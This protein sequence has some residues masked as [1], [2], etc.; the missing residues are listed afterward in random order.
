MTVRTAPLGRVPLVDLTGWRGHLTA[1]AVV[2]FAILALFHADVWSMVSIWWNASTFGHCLFI[3]PLIAWLVQQRLSGLRQL[4]PVAWTP[5]LVWLALGAL[6]WLVGAAAG[7]AMVRHGALVVMLQGAT[8]ALLGPAVARAL[9]FPL[10][11]AFF[12]VPFGEEIVPPLQ[13]VTAR[14]A[15][16]FLDLSG[17]PAHM[18]GIFI[19]TPTGYFEVAEACS[20]AK[21]L[22]AM[23]AYGVL[24]CNVCFRTWP[25]RI[26]FMIGAL[27][28]SVLANGV[29]AFATILVAHL[30]SVDAAV[31]FDHVVYGWV[32]FAIIMIVV[33]AT[34]WPF[35]DRKPG[36]AWFDPAQLQGAV[37]YRTSTGG[38]AGTA[39][40][41]IVAAPLWLAATAAS[42]DPLPSRI[43][44]PM[45][46][47]WT[48]TEAAQAYPWTPRFDGADHRATGHYRNGAGQ[49]VDLT[50]V[51][52][53]DQ[54][55][56]RKLVGFGQGAAD[57]DS[58]WV[59][60]SPARAPANARG[61]QITAP[62]PV[63]RHVV[64]FYIV[65]QGAPTGS[66]PKVKIE[67]MKARLLGQDQ[68][69]IAILVSAQ[70]GE[71]QSSDAAI[72]A[73]LTDLG[74]VKLLADRAMGLR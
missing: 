26:V 63:V 30:T 6:A 48:P 74:D 61:E 4:E 18:E 32:F 36:D 53:A 44:L 33:M 39:L 11:Y 9:I 57:P 25:R 41:L 10:F 20:G 55:E 43:D 42:A 17:V 54:D 28:L 58:E 37:R 65:G 62:G 21:F 49:I 3:P 47:G 27:G 72:S 34:A 14:L 70:E 1:L 69:A 31:G 22:I 2:A 71:G 5:G 56:G 68:R 16:L 40:A 60:S 24:V 8:I 66:R 23:T 52:Y 64:S 73:F 51:A 35:F 50:I 67:T 7:V 45:V 46:K 59:W 12:M 13:L 19:T 29:R 15:M 38:V